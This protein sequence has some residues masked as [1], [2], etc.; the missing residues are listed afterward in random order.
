MRQPMYQF[1]ASDY[2]ASR[3]DYAQNWKT[4]DQI[5]YRL[6][7][8]Y[9]L[10]SDLP[11]VTA[12][13]VIIGRAYATQIERKVS[14]KRTQGSSISQVAALFFD[15]HAEM[16]QWFV[17]IGKITGNLTASNIS[18][19]LTIHGLILGLLAKLTIRKQSVRTF[20]SKYMH[21]H[22]PVV[23]I[24]DSVADGFLPQLISLEDIQIPAAECVDVTYARYAYG[25]L[26]LYQS[27]TSQGVPVTMRL[28]DSYLMWKKQNSQP[29]PSTTGKRASGHL[30]QMKWDILD[31]SEEL[32]ADRDVRLQNFGEALGKLIVPAAD[33][34]ERLDVFRGLL[35]GLPSAITFTMG[36]PHSPGSQSIP[37]APLDEFRKFLGMPIIPDTDPALD[38]VQAAYE[39]CSRALLIL[40]LD[41][42]SEN[43]KLRDGYRWEWIENGSVQSL[44]LIPPANRGVA[45]S[46]TISKHDE[47]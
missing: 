25:F 5:L 37:V 33:Q 24:Y 18:E 28:L 32:M 4:V 46:T 16:D 44:E 31:L 38:E 20:V 21:F 15:H 9:P 45:P 12:K 2:Y 7:S 30:D 26:K 19:I 39:D 14:T 11:S 1:S 22:N 34:Q 8:E 41:K 42:L 40:S 29:G 17:R 10:H 36:T 6:C 3:E 13:V 23:P 27:A 47:P 35:L 43:L